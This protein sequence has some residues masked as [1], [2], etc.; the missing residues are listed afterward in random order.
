MIN[1]RWYIRLD[2]RIRSWTNTVHDIVGWPFQNLLRSR[3]GQ[4]IRRNTEPSHWTLLR[5]PMAIVI[6]VLLYLHH[7]G[8]A[9]GLYVLSVL[10]D[11]FDGEFARMDNKCSDFGTLLDT[12]ADS[13]MQS[14]ILLSLNNRF[15]IVF[16]SHPAWRLPLIAV[17]LEIVRLFGGLTL[18][19]LPKFV[20]RIQALEPNMSGKFKMAAMALS[21]LA[22]LCGVTPL[23]QQLM[24][25]AIVL[26]VYSML[27][28]LYDARTSPAA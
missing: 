22:I 6:F 28:H 23:A 5:F 12:I 1:V 10:T 18:H 15:P 17:C 26:S 3:V 8:Y 20:G 24:L 4:W 7:D 9:I 27:R 11:R 25:A 16:H 13:V 14:I 19:S 21:V 2:R